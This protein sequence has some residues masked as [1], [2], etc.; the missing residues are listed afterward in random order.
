[1]KN[2]TRAFTLIETI[3][4]IAIFSLLMTVS[5]LSFY[6]LFAAGKNS[7]VGYTDEDA[8]IVASTTIPGEL[9]SFTL[10]ETE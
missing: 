1:M 2:S 10:H 9:F 8:A 3:C 7:G 4:Y 6:Q 5:V